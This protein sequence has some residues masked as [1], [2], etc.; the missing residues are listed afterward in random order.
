MKKTIIAVLLLISVAAI[1]QKVDASKIPASVKA[2]FS[3]NFPGLAQVKWEREKGN[4]EAGFTQNGLKMSAVFDEK[5]NL[6]E[7]ETAIDIANLP[8]GAKEYIAQNYKGSKIKEAA[9]LKMPNGDINYEAEVKDSD[10]IFDASGKFI[11]K[12]KIEFPYI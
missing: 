8:A 11:K 6:I 3:K 9:M 12:T 2:S 1:A 7:T 5:G 4:F 10:L